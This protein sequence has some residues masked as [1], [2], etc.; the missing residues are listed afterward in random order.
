MT[1]VGVPPRPA[2]PGSALGPMR[3]VMRRPKK[4]RLVPS[5]SVGGTPAGS[6]MIQDVAN[7]L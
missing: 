3:V 7:G 5:A 6:S 1:W 2:P 4:N